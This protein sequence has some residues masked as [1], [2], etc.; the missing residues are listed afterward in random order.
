M[1]ATQSH[2]KSADIRKMQELML[3]IDEFVETGQ[4]LD[5]PIDA[6][7]NSRGFTLG[8]LSFTAKDFQSRDG[9]FKQSILYTNV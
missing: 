9:H 5:E 1:D 4:D 7:C 3:E 8:S 2:P 6:W